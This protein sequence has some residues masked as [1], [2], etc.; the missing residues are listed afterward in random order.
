MSGIKEKIVD[1]TFI[2]RRLHMGM[3]LS[4]ENQVRRVEGLGRVRWVVGLH[5]WRGVSV[6]ASIHKTCKDALRIMQEASIL[7]NVEAVTVNARNGQDIEI[8]HSIDCRLLSDNELDKLEGPIKER[9]AHE[10]AENQHTSGER[11]L[12]I[13]VEGDNTRAGVYCLVVL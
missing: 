7:F 8:C 6:R 3:A 12:A 11:R 10:M 13:S 4:I 1:S 5:V 2:G 9:W